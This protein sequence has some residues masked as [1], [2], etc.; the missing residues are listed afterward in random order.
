VR[1]PIVPLLPAYRFGAV[2]DPAN[3]LVVAT[4]HE[5]YSSDPTM[6]PPTVDCGL[7]TTRSN[8]DDAS[9]MVSNTVSITGGS[10]NQNCANQYDPGPT[11]SQLYSYDAENHHISVHGLPP[12]TSSGTLSWSPNGA[13]YN[14]GSTTI[15]Y[16]T[17]GSILFTT[18]AAGALFDIKVEALANVYG[19]GHMLVFDRDYAS[20]RITEHDNVAYGAVGFGSTI[21]R[22]NNASTTFPAVFPGST[23]GDACATG[24]CPR[25]G[26][27]QYNRAEGFD[28]LGVTFQGVRAVD[29]AS[30][31]WTT[32]DVYAGDVHDP[33]SQKPFMWDRNNPYEYSDPSG[34]SPEGWGDQLSALNEIA[35]APKKIHHD[36]PKGK[37]QPKPRFT[38]AWPEKMGQEH[39]PDTYEAPRGGVRR[40]RRGDYV[41]AYG[42][43]WHAPKPGERH[44]EPHW[45]VNGKEWEKRGRG[46]NEP[47]RRPEPIPADGAKK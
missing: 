37:P 46:H 7:Q 36:R 41:D 16:D 28:Y 2:I 32:P 23:N 31:Q 38:H 45:D 33:M 24:V 13:A 44:G 42:N 30:G 4:S 27:L 14:I 39:L 3:A 43:T 26:N 10:G 34:Y 25:V 40:D 11:T 15:H 8:Y 22:N 5:V 35:Y 6:T 29:N 20:Q 1:I 18:D 19:N 12:L 47:I 21:Y 17:D 9:R